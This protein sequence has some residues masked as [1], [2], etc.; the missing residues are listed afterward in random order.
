MTAMPTI[1]RGAMLGMALAGAI[2]PTAAPAQTKLS[3]DPDDLSVQAV[4]NYGVCIADTT[5]RG[6]VEVLAMDFRSSEY[7]NRL[8]AL[9]K[10][11]A[12]GRCLYDG[13]IRYAPVLL[14]GGMAERLLLRGNVDRLRAG[15]AIDPANADLKP[16]S[17]TEATALCV[18]RAQ[19]AEVWAIF[20]TEPATRPELEAMKAIAPALPG[21]IPAGRKMELNKPGLRAML[22]LAAYR[23][24]NY[25]ATPG[26]GS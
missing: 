19:P 2:L 14:A 4:H 11:H 21:C 5:P 20:Q 3:S 10:G 25:P 12:D 22:A 23:L 9:S 17:A 24:V 7:S 8:R 6:A 26:Q 15:A 18:I 13:S 1:A 16:R